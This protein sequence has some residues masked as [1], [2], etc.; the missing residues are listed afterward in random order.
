[1]AR[2][3]EAR[4]A[5]LWVDSTWDFRLERPFNDWELDSLQQFLCVVGPK[6]LKPRNDDQNL[7]KYYENSIFSISSCFRLLEGERQIAAPN[8][9]LWNPVMPSKVSF[10]AYE[11]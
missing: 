1:M 11:I 3:K 5:D 4:V 9:M 10:F 6:S 7:W 8:E 2:S